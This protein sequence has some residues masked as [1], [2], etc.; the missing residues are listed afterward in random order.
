VRSPVSG[1]TGYRVG[2]AVVRRLPEPV[3]AALFAAGGTVAA[4]R[5]GRGV[6]RLRGNLARVTGLSGDALEALVGRALRSYARYWREAFRLPSTD[7]AQVADRYDVSG[8]R[9]GLAPQQSGRGVVFA[10]PH[11]GN[12]DAAGV[13]LVQQGVPFTTVAERLEPAELFDAFVAYRESLG[14]E[15]LALTGGERPPYEVLEARLRAPGAVC[16]L[17]DRDLSARGMPVHFFGDGASMPAGPALLALRTGAALV[18][19]TLGFSGRGRW[20]G[21]MHPELVSTLDGTEEERVA[22]LTQQLADVFAGAIAADPQDWH[23]LGR[24]WRDG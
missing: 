7:P 23:V 4:R 22:D 19:F 13:W 3:A 16:L 12:W 6:D 10:L 18:P 11:M 24:V 1:A 20:H 21:Q 8:W 17:A 15:V 14:M 2:W 9:A 5:G